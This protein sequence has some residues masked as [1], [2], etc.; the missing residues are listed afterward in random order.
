M[1]HGHTRYM[2]FADAREAF[3]RATHSDALPEMQLAES[4][5]PV[6]IT[7][8]HCWAV[9]PIGVILAFGLV[10]LWASKGWTGL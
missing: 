7:G 2:R 5:Q 1:K 8:S 9:I 3:N 6:E 4:N 10:A